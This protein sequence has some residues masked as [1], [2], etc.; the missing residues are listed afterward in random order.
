[1]SPKCHPRHGWLTAWMDRVEFSRAPGPNTMGSLPFSGQTPDDMPSSFD[2]LTAHIQFPIP[3]TPPRYSPMVETPG[4]IQD[5]LLA[6]EQ[7]LSFFH[8]LF[9]LHR[10]YLASPSCFDPKRLHTIRRRVFYPGSILSKVLAENPWQ[11]V[12]TVSGVR[13]S[14]DLCWMGSLLFINFA[15]WDF[16]NQPERLERYLSWLE[17]EVRLKGLDTNHSVETLLWV[18]WRDSANNGNDCIEEVDDSDVERKDTRHGCTSAFE[19]KGVAIAKNVEE[20][21]W[22]VTRMLRVAKRLGPESWEKVR[23]TLLAFMLA[24]EQNEDDTTTRIKESPGPT[25]QLNRLPWEEDQLRR[26]ILATLYVS[27]PI[28]KDATMKINTAG[29]GQPGEPQSRPPG[30]RVIIL[31]TSFG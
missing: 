18:F 9:A 5:L 24:P 19:R 15:L 20:R 17:N 1:M 6:C 31:G 14:K 25:R 12:R 30:H 13:Y 27:S 23:D 16:S 2:F 11:Y 22:F 7:F 26:E 28:F 3:Y 8:H 21:N 10:Q 29:F 4:E